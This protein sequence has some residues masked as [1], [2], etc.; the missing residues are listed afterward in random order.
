VAGDVDVGA[1]HT[2]AAARLEGAV[3]LGFEGDPSEVWIDV[4]ADQTTKAYGNPG[5][6]GRFAFDG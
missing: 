5:P 4:V 2:V 3:T 1:I 6:D